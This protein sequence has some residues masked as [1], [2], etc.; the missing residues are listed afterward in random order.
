M[1][2][3]N[4]LQ[5]LVAFCPCGFSRFAAILDRMSQDG[6]TPA[7]QVSK[8]AEHLIG[9]EIIKLG[10]EVN[11]RIRQGE[12]ITN[13]TIGDFDPAVFPLPEVLLEHII[14]AYRE[15]HTNYPMANGVME[16]RNA[17][18]AWSKT[19]YGLDFDPSEVLIAGGARPIIYTIYATLLDP[20]DKVIYPVPSW[21][22]NHYCHL[23]GAEGICIECSPESNFMPLAADIEPHIKDAVLL[24]LCSPQNPT[25]TVFTK[26]QLEAICDLVIAENKRRGPGQKPVYIMYDQIYGA[27]LYGDNVH[28]NPVSLRSEL[29]PYTV[30]V[31]GI[32]KS[33]AATGVRVGWALGPSRIIDKMKSILG[34][35]GAWSPKAE[36]IATARFLADTS[37]T[38]SFSTEFKVEMHERL[39]GVY[40]GLETLRSEG[41]PVRCIEPRGAIYLTALFDLKGRRTPEGKVLETTDDIFSYILSTA[42]LAIVPFSAFGAST[43]SSWFRLSLGTC[44]LEDIPGLIQ[45]LRSSL[46]ALQKD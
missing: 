9:S 18:A 41:L 23:L 11:E 22:N 46:S 12:T 30:F 3:C 36:Q 16:L 31:D 15:G 20:G 25:G 14:L 27:L 35:I 38:T 28:Y 13:F 44:R 6:N 26:E 1:E 19:T 39:K 8:M 37:A 40:D 10:N 5:F 21:N 17:V 2:R 29:R 7:L 32:S 42:K 24:A 34:H 43:Q 45:R 4:E 33:F